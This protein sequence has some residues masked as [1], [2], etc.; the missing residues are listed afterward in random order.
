MTYEMTN[1]CSCTVYDDETGTFTAAEDCFGHCWEDAVDDFHNLIYDLWE[2]NPTYYWRIGGIRLWNR[3]VG[4]IAKCETPEDLI[5]AMTVNS[6]WTMRYNV[7]EDSIVY[8]LSHHDAPTG[9]SSF[10]T[11]PSEEEIDEYA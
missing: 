7:T 4:G 10:V 1:Q 3:E 11:I 6:S 2:K 5:R 8:S 9:S